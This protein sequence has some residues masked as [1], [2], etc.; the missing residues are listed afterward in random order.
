MLREDDRIAV[1]LVQ[2][3]PHHS[4]IGGGQVVKQAGLAVASVGYQQQDRVRERQRVQARPRQQLAMWTGRPELGSDD[5]QRHTARWYSLLFTLQQADEKSFDEL[6]VS[7][8]SMLPLRV[9][10]SNHHA[11]PVEV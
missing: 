2:R 11:E 3:I 4:C 7:G 10:P 5:V 8:T 6:R 9:S 1:A